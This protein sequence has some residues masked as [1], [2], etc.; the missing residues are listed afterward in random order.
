MTLLLVQT[1]VGALVQTRL[2]MERHFNSVCVVKTLYEMDTIDDCSQV[3]SN[4]YGN[5]PWTC[6]ASGA[7]VRTC[8]V[9]PCCWGTVG[10]HKGTGIMAYVQDLKSP[11]GAICPNDTATYPLGDITE[12]V[13]LWLLGPQGSDFPVCFLTPDRTQ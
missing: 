4:E 7:N 6:T 1:P 9:E 12:S 2:D 3:A 5:G 13:D 10:A 11:R 8:H